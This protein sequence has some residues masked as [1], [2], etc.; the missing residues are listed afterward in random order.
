VG[1]SH[2]TKKEC[3]VFALLLKTVALIFRIVCISLPASL[4]IWLCPIFRVPLDAYGQFKDVATNTRLFS[5]AQQRLVGQDLRL[6]AH[7][8]TRYTW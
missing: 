8:Q 2:K 3:R 7:T 1:C 6:H 4:W 5:M